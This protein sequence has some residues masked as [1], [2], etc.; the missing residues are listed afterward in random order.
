M[1]PTFPRSI[2]FSPWHDGFAGANRSMLTLA[3][4][5]AKRS[6]GALFFIQEGAVSAEARRLGLPVYTAFRHAPP[7]PAVLGAHRAIGAFRK[8]VREQ[9]A[10]ILHCH[11]AFGMR[12]ARVLALAGGTKLVCHQ[13]DNYRAD[14]R[15]RYLHEATWIIAISNWVH[16]TLPAAMQRNAT[17]IHNA[18][19]PIVDR[20]GPTP[21]G[22]APLAVRVGMAGRCI[23]EKGFDTFIEAAARLE[24]EPVEFEIWGVDPDPAP[25][26]HDGE[27]QALLRALPA[28]LRSRI[29]VR[30]FSVDVDRFFER[31]DVVVVP[32]RFAEPFG[33]MAI[34]AMNHGKAVIVAGH[35]GLVEIVDDGVNGRRFRPGDAAQ[36][37][38]IVREL[39]HDAAQRESLALRGRRH[40][41]SRFAATDHC[42]AVLRLYAALP[43]EGLA[44]RVGRFL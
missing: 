4:E 41:A 20:P 22:D 32:S 40:V 30:P 17:V 18:V 24:N 13:R 37:A 19:L 43:D 23:R 15:H 7:W 9:E 6:L 16:S 36:L 39:V 26:S 3:S 31:C 2:H 29:R 44:R 8:A 28:P 25:G 21:G 38:T 11:G 12:I 10:T 27:I 5:I 42:D 33:R 35:G 34:E 1:T 14:D